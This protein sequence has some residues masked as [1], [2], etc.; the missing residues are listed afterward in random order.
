MHPSRLCSPYASSNDERASR[1]KT[2]QISRVN[3]ARPE[4][5]PD[6]HRETRLF[7]LSSPP[8]SVLRVLSLLFLLLLLLFLFLL[9]LLL[10]VLS[11][12]RSKY[13]GGFRT[14]DYRADSALFV[15]VASSS[16]E[17]KKNLDTSGTR[18][19]NVAVGYFGNPSGRRL[20]HFE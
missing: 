15:H 12:P 9:P 19:W 2:A 16:E 20:A 13:I 8:L 14:T 5:P 3:D 10:F 6:L 1:R 11:F 4:I 18:K 17:R 7:S